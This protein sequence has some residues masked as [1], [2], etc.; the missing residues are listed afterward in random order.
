MATDSQPVSDRHPRLS[1]SAAR[2]PVEEIGSV[3]SPV[4]N[5]VTIASAKEGR[6]G[7]M[8]RVTLPARFEWTWVKQIVKGDDGQGLG[9]GR[10]RK[11]RSCR[12]RVARRGGPAWMR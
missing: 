1:R 10:I 3:R 8:I 5:A 12:G 2:N 6:P 4:R 11:E 7:A 9:G